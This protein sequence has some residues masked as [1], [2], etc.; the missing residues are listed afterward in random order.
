MEISDKITQ[1]EIKGMRCVDDLTLNLNGLNVLVGANGSGKSTILEALVLLS[2]AAQ[3]R[4]L[5]TAISKEHGGLMSLLR[6]G[7]TELYLGVWIESSVREPSISY[8]LGLGFEG[9]YPMIIHESLNVFV[10]GQDKEPLTAITRDRTGCSVFH[11]GQR[12][13]MRVN[14]GEDSE[15]TVLSGYSKLVS[16]DILPQAIGR[17]KR[18]L[19]GI[20]TFASFD[21]RPMWMSLESSIPSKIRMPVTLERV[22]FLSR[23]GENLANCFHFLRNNPKH[24]QAVLDLARLGLGEDLVDIITPAFNQGNIELQ[25]KFSA[26]ENPVPVSCLSNGQICFLAIIV[27]TALL[28]DKK[29]FLLAFDEPELH[30]HPLLLARVVAMFEELGLDHTVVL[31]THSDRLLDALQ[32]PA[33]SVVLCELSSERT[34]KLRKVD[35]AALDDWLVDYRGL[36]HLRIEGYESLVF[37]ESSKQ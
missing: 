17:V 34:C 14:L 6:H 37:E 4:F 19:G 23:G 28:K 26:S 24:W 32:N 29:G 33:D 5:S 1:L 18:V 16:A 36:G 30:L 25:L 20:H 15:S 13:L 9:I 27:M 35:R 7:C 21:V 10:H 22:N 2:K 8:S 3:S 11:W 31:A 12:K